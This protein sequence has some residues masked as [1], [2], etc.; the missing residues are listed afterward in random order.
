[1][2]HFSR[3]ERARRHLLQSLLDGEHRPGSVI[4]IKD[5][6]VVL[7]ISPTPV[8]EALERLAGEGIV[9]TAQ[10]GRGF[11][12]ARHGARELADLFRVLE[13]LLRFAYQDRQKP[14]LVEASSLTLDKEHPALA[15]QSV[16]GLVA[17]HTRSRTLSGEIRRFINLLAPYRAQEPRIIPN[18]PEELD[19]L[20]AGLITENQ[21]M[22]S[23]RMHTR[24]RTQCVTVLIESVENRHHQIY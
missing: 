13:V 9:Q 4:N 3:V 14:I 5:I 15:V 2:Q 7:G 22:Q 6:A 21:V 1:M 16:L 11:T 18:W 17:D 10:S 8:R 20:R 24:L 23:L 19:N 12:A